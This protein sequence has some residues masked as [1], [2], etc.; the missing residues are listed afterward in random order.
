MI[1]LTHFHA[2]HPTGPF[3]YP[4]KTSRK[5]WFSNVFRTYKKGPVACYGFNNS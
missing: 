1:P 5:L 3:L 2:F 4:L